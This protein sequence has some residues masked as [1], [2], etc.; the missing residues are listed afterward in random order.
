M[1]SASTA[2]TDGSVTIKSFQ[3]D[4]EGKGAN[5][6]RNDGGLGEN[7]VVENGKGRHD[8]FVRTGTGWSQWEEFVCSFALRDKSGLDESMEMNKITDTEV[9][10]TKQIVQRS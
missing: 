10:I 1:R 9:L 6:E 8:G 5:E 4:V 2:E 3:Q 7:E